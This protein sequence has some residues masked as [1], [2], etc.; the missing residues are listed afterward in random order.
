MVIVNTGLGWGG[1]ATPGKAPRPNLHF[2]SPSASHNRRRLFFTD[3]ASYWFA[4]TLSEET[5]EA[6]TRHWGIVPRFSREMA[7][8]HGIG[9]KTRY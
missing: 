7:Q 4:R 1:G 8:A 6:K 3:R 2:R 5:W 9:A